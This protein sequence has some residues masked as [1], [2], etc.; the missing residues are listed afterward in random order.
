MMGAG[1]A[2]ANASR[3]IPCVLKDVSLEKAQAGVAAIEKIVAPQVAKGRMADAERGALLQRVTATADV[4]DLGGCDLI[5]E[6]VFERRDL[7]AAVT[8]E[9]EP[10]LAEGGVFAS[11][12][13][14]LP[15]GGLAEAS[16]RPERFVGLHFFSP[17]HKMKL[18]EIIRGRATSDETLARAFD[19]VAALGKTP[20]RRQRFARLLHEPRVRHFRDGRRGDAGR[21]RPGAAD[22]TSRA[23]RRHAGRTARGRRRDLA[24][25]VGAGDGPDPRRSEG[26]RAHRRAGARRVAHRAHGQGARATGTRRRGRLL[27]LSERRAEAPVAGAEA[28][29]RARRRRDRRSMR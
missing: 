12:T 23:R 27:R 18:V 7:K 28:A 19:Y 29:V 3:G 26:R 2:H 17:V 8:R 11:N 9:A 6:A 14:T 24:V 25:V 16:A 15:I 22:R 21:R 4:A 20:I 5:I 10:M 13:S 1:I